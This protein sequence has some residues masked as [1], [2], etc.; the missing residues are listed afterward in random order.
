MMAM[1]MQR[2]NKQWLLKSRPSD[3]L[4]LEHFELAEQT[5]PPLTENQVLLENHYLSFDPTQRIWAA[6][7]SYLPKVALDDVMRSFGIGQ[8][9]ESTSSKY[10]VGDMVFTNIGWQQ[11]KLLDLNQKEITKPVKIPGFLDPVTLLALS[12]TGFTA[13]IGMTKLAKVKLGDDVLV[14]GAAGAV[15]SMVCQIAKLKGARVVGIAGGEQKC[16]HLI[17]DLAIDASIDYKNE[18]VNQRIDDLFPQGVDIYFDNVGGEILDHV[19]TKLKKHARII[20]CGAISQYHEVTQENIDKGISPATKNIFNL[21][22]QSATMQGFVLTDYMQDMPK[23]LL[24]LSKW[25]NQD[26]IKLD[27]DM[28]HGFDNIPQTLNR[29]FT[30]QNKGKQLLTITEPHLAKNSSWLYKYIYRLASLFS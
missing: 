14:S 23:A 22:A 28:Q 21:I 1:P 27:I 16:K 18:P 26:K 3:L 30:G 29:L 13:Y 9:I 4:T 5:V 24:K 15:G 7:D 6:I 2:V 10:K 11:Y 17:E 25:V 12:I 20:L 19:L 8:V